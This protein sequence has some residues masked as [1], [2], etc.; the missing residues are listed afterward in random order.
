MSSV[1]PFF[2]TMDTSAVNGAPAAYDDDDILVLQAIAAVVESN[3]A[4]Y[5]ILAE[6]G[7]S[8]ST[9]SISALLEV[10]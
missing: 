1:A 9:P 8:L 4:I 3:A 6:D 7:P 2:R 5:S 10:V